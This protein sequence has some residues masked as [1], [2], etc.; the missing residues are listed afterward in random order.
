MK[1]LPRLSFPIPTYQ[2]IPKDTLGLTITSPLHIYRNLV[3]T[4]VIS[5]DPNQHRAAIVIQ[6]VY[7]RLLDYKPERYTDLKKRLDAVTNSLRALE[8]AHKK[9]SHSQDGGG[10]LQKHKTTWRDSP[11]LPTSLQ[12]PQAQSKALIR[13][14]SRDE[15]LLNISSP[16][17]LLLSGNVGCGKS[18][19]TD[20]LAESLPVESKRRVHFDTFMLGV[21]G[22]LEDFRIKNSYTNHD[23]DIGEGYSILH[24]AKEMVENS[25]VLILDEFQMPD[26]ASGKIL[27]SLLNTFFMMGG[28]LIATSNRLPE[29]LVSTEWRKKEEFGVFEEV[30]KRRCE[31]WDMNSIVDWRRRGGEGR[32][33]QVPANI[34]GEEERVVEVPKFYF[35]KEGDMQEAWEDAVEKAAV[36]R[37]QGWSERGLVVYGR[38]VLLKR[39]RNG[40]ALFNFDELCVELLGPA[41]YITIASNFSTIII[42][43]I[44]VLTSKSH[45]HEAR[46]FITLLD[47]IYECRCKLLI[48]AEVP[49]EDLFFPDAAEK[50]GSS[51]EEDSIHSE[52]FAE[53]HQDLT[54]PFRPNVSLYE[55]LPEDPNDPLT[56]KRKKYTVA[57]QDSDFRGKVDFTSVK[58]YTGEDEKFSF[59]R[60]VS[61]V[62][63]VCGERWWDA[64]SYSGEESS[65]MRRVT[66]SP[67]LRSLRRWEGGSSE[68]DTN[69]PPALEDDTPTARLRPNAPQFNPVHIW[70]VIDTWGKRAGRWGKG[71]NAYKDDDTRNKCSDTRGGK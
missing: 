59:K 37:E 33:V 11:Y 20:I 62:W 60:A 44:P 45:R 50:Q 46:R 66:H 26:K 10:G 36:G 14:F 16:R 67:M 54:V 39:A 31:V 61:R 41:D 19:L 52:A 58:K 42:D 21:Y 18:M 8:D 25:T 63:E 43:R 23:R 13:T 68:V 29:T 32:I 5:A 28:V 64:L 34:A 65:A 6:G 48:R 4:N 17:G 40:A 71:V 7:D 56:W 38:E 35:L 47:A 53:A 15:E 22:M 57:D 55:Q 2:H 12:S 9:S 49:I 69:I 70:G 30:L 1:Y 27:K 3:A 24:V 51:Q